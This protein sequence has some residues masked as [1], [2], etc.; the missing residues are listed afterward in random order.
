MTKEK[1]VGGR[2]PDQPGEGKINAKVNHPATK[3]HCH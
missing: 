2:I 1:K 3:R